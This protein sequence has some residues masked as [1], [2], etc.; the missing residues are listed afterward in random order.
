MIKVVN[1]LLEDSKHIKNLLSYPFNSVIVKWQ[2]IKLIE[3]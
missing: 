2:I 1:L 3:S